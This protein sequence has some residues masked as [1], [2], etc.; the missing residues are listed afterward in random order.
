MHFELPHRIY[1]QTEYMPQTH[2]FALMRKYQLNQ[3]RLHPSLWC[4]SADLR[5]LSAHMRNVLLYLCAFL[6]PANDFSY[7]HLI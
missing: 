1:D 2:Q 4:V 3:T 6:G 7:M 5:V